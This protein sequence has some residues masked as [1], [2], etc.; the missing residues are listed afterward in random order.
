[1]LEV[2]SLC[3][4][5]QN[6]FS[7]WH[8]SRL[9]CLS[10]LIL[11]I[12]MV[13]TINLVQISTAFKGRAKQSSNYKRITRFMSDFNLP[14]DSVAHFIEQTFP[15]G[16]TWSI[17]I[18]RTNWKFG[19]KDINVFVLAICYQGIAVPLLFSTLN[20]RANTKTADR[21]TMLERFIKLFGVGKIKHVLG[22]R[23]FIG[24]EWLK[25]LMSKQIPFIIRL[26]SDILISN[27]KGRGK[28]SKNFF[29]DL[30]PNSKKFL[31]RRMVLG[32]L[33]Y[34]VGEKTITGECKILITDAKP[35]NA[36]C[37]YAKRQEIE[38]M[39]GCLKTRGFNF[40]STHMTELDRIDNLL[41]VMTI[42][43][44]L[45]Y[46]TGDIFKDIVPIKLKSHG[47][48]E[49]SIFRHG[50]DYLRRLMINIHD[51]ANEF[52]GNLAI[53]QRKTAT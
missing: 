33:V 29:R 52:F 18:D 30:A 46:R 8:L 24:K 28:P 27:S 14:F 9:K 43:F 41:A 39:F 45:S 23:E 2:L 13:K 38:T 42:A 6:H 51:R 15:F 50:Y 44:A 49:K 12:M 21:I 16:D 3:A 25:F 26:R 47:D 22:D 5:L 40:E 31:G 35:E 48:R 11:A 19:K 37:G 34:V 36:M 53:I 4:S 32:S 17:A 10:Q 1:M 20:K 7:D